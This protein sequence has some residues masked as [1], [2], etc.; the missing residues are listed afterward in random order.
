MSDVFDIVFE[1]PSPCC[2]ESMHWEWN[3]EDLVFESECNCMKRYTLRPTAA[4]IEHE[5]EEFEA[6]D[7]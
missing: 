6:D 7:E 1:S 2:S 3:D 5:S 4:E